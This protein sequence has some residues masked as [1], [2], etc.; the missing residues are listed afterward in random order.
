MATD[1][2]DRS[3]KALSASDLVAVGKDLVALLRDSALL[4]LAVLLIALPATFNDILQKAGFEEGSVVGFKWKTKLV[5][6][7]AALKEAQATITNYKEQNEQLTKALA[8]AQKQSNSASLKEHLAKLTENNTQLNIASSSV[9]ASLEATIASNAPLVQKAQASIDQATTWGVVFGG[10]TALDAAKYETG[11]VAPKLGIADA[12]V[13]FRQGSFRSVAI[14]PERS[15]AEQLLY[16]AKGR[17][18]DA[19]VVNMSTWCPRV[20]ERVGY[21]ECIA[22]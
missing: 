4:L 3:P 20:E 18:P 11:T 15:Q 6:S 13:Y 10:D 2:S 5:E 14:S 19:Y 1:S 7:D 12:L 17:R 8:E 21:R 22:P 16:K 9:A